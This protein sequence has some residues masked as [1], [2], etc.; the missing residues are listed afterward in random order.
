MPD[1]KPLRSQQTGQAELAPDELRRVR[2]VLNVTR[3]LTSKGKLDTR[4]WATLAAFRDALRAAVDL[5]SARD[6]RRAIK[7]LA[8]KCDDTIAQ[9]DRRMQAKRDDAE[10]VG[11]TVEK[12]RWVEALRLDLVKL[13]DCIRDDPRERSLLFWKFLTKEAIAEIE[14]LRTQVDSRLENI[15]HEAQIVAAQ[16]GAKRV[17]GERDLQEMR[18]EARELGAALLKRE[19]AFSLGVEILEAITRN[20]P[21]DEVAVAA[22]GALGGTRAARARRTTGGLGQKG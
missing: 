22:R 11:V 8:K 2:N 18:R 1:D 9:Y 4:E 14:A 5:P 7:S 15:R 16:A 3:I 17:R 21:E 19:I 12:K 10:A 20:D 13:H 6:Q